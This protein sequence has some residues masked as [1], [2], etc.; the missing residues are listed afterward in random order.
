[1]GWIAGEDTSWAVPGDDGLYQEPM[2]VFLWKNATDD[3]T[4]EDERDL[5]LDYTDAAASAAALLAEAALEFLQSGPIAHWWEAAGED[6]A[7]ITNQLASGVRIANQAA[8]I[9]RLAAG[10]VIRLLSDSNAEEKWPVPKVET[11]A[12]WRARAKAA[13]VTIED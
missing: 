7:K 13:G 10:A 12:S 1:M 8:E 6:D 5:Y 11:E 3:A 4:D 2:L 9:G